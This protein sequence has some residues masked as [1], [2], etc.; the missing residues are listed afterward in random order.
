MRVTIG[1][2]N[3]YYGPYQLAKTLCFWAKPVKDEYG[4]SDTP[5]WVHNFGE[6]LAHGSVEREVPG[7][8]FSGE[9]TFDIKNRK[10]RHITWL[11]KFLMWIDDKKKR[12]I[13]VRIDDHDV[14]AMDHTLALIIH[15][16]LIKLKEKKIGS[17]YVDDE[18]V[19]E[20]LR[21][22]EEE[23]AREL[24]DGSVTDKHHERWNYV[25][26]EMIYAFETIIDDDIELRYYE[27]KI[28]QEEFEQIR[29][30]IV[31]G[32]TLFGKYYQNLWN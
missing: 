23:K 1:K 17:P 31:K 10:E 2:Y 30:R 11:Y 24:K 16:M 29:S 15:P 21:D 5:D 3:T 4:F 27:D 26:A 13:K 9:L 28:T 19:P 32:T 18:D 22:T 25:L 6:W 12:K 14:W 20:H 8:E 7:R